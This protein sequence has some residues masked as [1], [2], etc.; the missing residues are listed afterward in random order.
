MAI[1]N[2]PS[3]WSPIAAG[4]DVFVKDRL[5]RQQ[6][7]RQA[8]QDAWNREARGRQRQNWGYIDQE[9]AYQQQQREKAAQAQAEQDAKALVA[10]TRAQELSSQFTERDPRMAYTGIVPG[11]TG[12]GTGDDEFAGTQIDP[13]IATFSEQ[14][15]SLARTLARHPG[16]P[17]PSGA[18][19]KAM[20]GGD[21]T[22]PTTDALTA[23][24]G[25][26][27]QYYEKPGTITDKQYIQALQTA[28]GAKLLAS[29]RA[30]SKPR[31]G[32]STQGPLDTTE[33]KRLMDIAANR[34]VS[35]GQGG[36][37]GAGATG[38]G[39]GLDEFAGTGP[40]P[41]LFS[42]EDQ[43]RALSRA[44]EML[45]GRTGQSYSDF[46]NIWAPKE[47]EVK[48]L[49]LS[50]VG[51][52]GL[53]QG[54]IK[55]AYEGMFDPRGEELSKIASV[56]QAGLQQYG[57]VGNLPLADSQ[58][59]NLG[60]TGDITGATQDLIMRNMWQA[61]QILHRQNPTTSA[62]AIFENLMENVGYGDRGVDVL[63]IDESMVSP[64]EEGV[65]PVGLSDTMAS[66][67]AGIGEQGGPTLKSPQEIAADYQALL[68]FSQ[69]HQ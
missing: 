52:S 62:R 63:G 20:L 18:V 19:Y 43:A 17:Q 60:T 6:R 64:Y 41:A 1:I 39:T 8:E 9:R 46:E 57:G 7:E 45:E 67:R 59:S 16:A 4:I 61:A 10:E 65:M 28:Q 42:P 32:T 29:M 15:N 26:M 49:T 51:E 11:Y 48:P 27:R 34:A 12:Y 66:Y 38:F 13:R 56:L 58:G 30:A 50:S 47:D 44:H 68:E 33:L 23:A 24:L 14:Q 3:S 54:G 55:S 40:S 53:T 2:I 35:V 22:A 25:I 5:A 36:V 37:L 31:A 21:D 69:R